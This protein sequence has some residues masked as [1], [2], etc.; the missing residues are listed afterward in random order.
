MNKEQIQE[1][2]NE[3]DYTCN[4]LTHTIEYLQACILELL[5]QREWLSH[6]LN[7]LSNKKTTLW[8]KQSKDETE[9]N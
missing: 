3:I 4:S 5:K 8:F 7:R 6:E 9:T 2:I 1:Q